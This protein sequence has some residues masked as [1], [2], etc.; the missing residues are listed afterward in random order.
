MT[1][2][3]AG[4]GFTLMELLVSV[5]IFILL[6]ILLVGLLRSGVEI[7]DRGES[8]RDAY[9]RASILFDALRSDLSCA[10]IHREA[11]PAGLNPN[12]TCL[13]DRHHRP[14]LFFTRVGLVPAQGQQAAPTGYK[15]KDVTFFAAADTMKRH[16]VI[17]CFDPDGGS[18][19]LYRGQFSF[20]NDY[21]LKMPLDVFGRPDWI[22]QNVQ[23]LADGVI[24][25]GLR[26]WS[27]RT[28]TWNP[29]NGEQGPEV[30]W[31]STR[32]RDGE[33]PL[34]R[35]GITLNDPLDDILPRRVEI[36]LTLERPWAQ[37]QAVSKLNADIDKN[38]GTLS[39]DLL[40]GFPQ[41]PGFVKIDDEW[42]WYE[43][44]SGSSLT[45]LRRGQRE[46]DRTTHK[47][48]ARLRWGETFTTV[49]GIPAYKDD[50][51]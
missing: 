35:P 46:T 22:A 48:G 9:E 13:P 25:L 19:K 45:G 37:G 31:D 51:N 17:Y 49:V 26:F 6:G 27:Q 36:T 18:G 28:V 15:D 42:I 10:T 32:F 21:G 38:S 33:F 14:L 43:T 44:R 8:R 40:P 16:E 20:N 29:A 34:K 3:R 7:W 39:A 4:A 5:A 41:G 1:R 2:T 24:Y 47:S 11:D 30:R 50:Q 23:L 12:F